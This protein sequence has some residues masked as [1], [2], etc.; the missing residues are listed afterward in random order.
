MSEHKRLTEKDKNGQMRLIPGDYNPLFQPCAVCTNPE[1]EKCPL[2]ILIDRL[3]QY[4]DI[5]SPEEFAELAKAKAEGRLVVLPVPIGSPV[6]KIQ[7]YGTYGMT[8][9]RIDEKTMAGYYKTPN[10]EGYVVTG[11][12]GEEDISPEYL[13]FSKEAAEKALKQIGGD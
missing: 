12:T 9:R 3:S 13:Y 1:C 5:G 7:P 11:D 2:P 4:E 6:Y 10:Y 8:K